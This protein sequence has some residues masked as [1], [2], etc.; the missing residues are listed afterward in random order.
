MKLETLLMLAGAALL[1]GVVLAAKRKPVK[2]VAPILV[3]LTPRPR[4]GGAHP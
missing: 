3:E 2:R 1:T 4:G